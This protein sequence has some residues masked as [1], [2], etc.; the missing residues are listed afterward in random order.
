MTR[1]APLLVPP[2]KEVEATGTS[3]AEYRHK[4]RGPVYQRG[5]LL[6]FWIACCWSVQIG[7][8]SGVA[9]V[10]WGPRTGR[11]MRHRLEVE[12]TFRE[13][14]FRFRHRSLQRSIR[15]LRPNCRTGWRSSIFWESARM[16][17]SL[18]AD[19]FKVP[20]RQDV[21]KFPSKSAR[22]PR[23]DRRKKYWTRSWVLKSACNGHS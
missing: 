23:K 12:S 19:G 8:K 5:M 16:E 4:L 7:V 20:S 6:R 11:K 9:C 1:Q 15:K 10:K 2:F 3:L 21:Q 18:L 14:H 22:F 13:S 17:S